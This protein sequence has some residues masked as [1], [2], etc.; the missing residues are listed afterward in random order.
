MQKILI[1]C[2]CCLTYAC[3]EIPSSELFSAENSA[4]E[5]QVACGYKNIAETDDGISDATT[6]ALALAIRCGAEYNVATEA[7]AAARLN[8]DNQRLM[9]REKRYT[10]ER[11]I[12]AFL[13]TVMSYRSNRL[14]G[15]ASQ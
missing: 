5:A 6:V 7:I 10:K 14:K 15:A 2:V 1:A 11:R 9:Y 8:N 12:D 3:A 13:S 4:L